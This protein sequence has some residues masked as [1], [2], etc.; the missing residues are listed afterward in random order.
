ATV[1]LWRYL[2]GVDLTVRVDAR[3]PV[4]DPL[5]HLLTDV[6]AAAPTARDQLYVRIVDA[7]RALAG[8]RYGTPVDAVLEVDDAFSPWN[9]GRWR[10]SGGPEGAVCD[11][12]DAEPDLGL[13]ARELGAAY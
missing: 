12:T 10:L 8:R 7:G 1:A 6:R 13:S 4:D 3:V 11:R 5:L 9:A 2:L